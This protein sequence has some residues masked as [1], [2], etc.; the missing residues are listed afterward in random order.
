MKNKKQDEHEIFNET[1]I[2]HMCSEN[3]SLKFTSKIKIRV[4]S[5]YSNEAFTDYV[6]T[7]SMF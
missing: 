2:Q 6:C 4:A 1:I 5:P 3:S 7:Q